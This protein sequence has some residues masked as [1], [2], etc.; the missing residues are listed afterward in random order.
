MN[1]II[2][3]FT[4]TATLAIFDS[5]ILRDRVGDGGDW[6]CLDF[7]SI[8]EVTDGRISLLS[9]GG[10]GT[11]SVRVTDGDLSPVE[12]DY[13][14]MALS[15]LGFEVVSSNV[16]VGKGECLPGEGFETSP[17]NLAKYEGKFL[18]VKPGKYNIDAF[19]I[20]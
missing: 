13:A 2:T 17:E 4:D 19:L 18:S 7:T 5:K 8:E 6:W 12:K 14:K 11:F 10:D 3:F 16:F 1:E 9:L 15:P 20:D